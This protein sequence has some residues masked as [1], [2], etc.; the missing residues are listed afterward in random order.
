MSDLR[1]ADIAEMTG[2]S[3]RYW[4]RRAA[5]GEIPETRVVKL[6]KRQT[7]L[8]RAD[9]FRRW[10][11]K[12]QVEVKPCRKISGGAEASGGIASPNP[13]RPSKGRFKPATS[14][15]LKSDLKVSAEC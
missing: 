15:S 14:E 13:A 5:A 4:Q 6:G 8:I 1:I 7:F 10:W 9:E 2:F 11:E 3:M 12:Q